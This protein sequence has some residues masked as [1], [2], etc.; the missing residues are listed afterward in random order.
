MVEEKTISIGDDISSNDRGQ[1][2]IRLRQV[3]RILEIGPLF[4]RHA[5]IKIKEIENLLCRIALD[6]RPMPYL[7]GILVQ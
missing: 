5:S 7:S 1:Y 4:V 3:L 2:M 6:Q